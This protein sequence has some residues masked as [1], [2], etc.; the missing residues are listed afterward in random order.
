MISS[1]ALKVTPQLSTKVANKRAGTLR[2]LV[3][4]TPVNAAGHM[5]ALT[6][7]NPT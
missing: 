6:V 3:T 7:K 1:P 4:V 5:L 2:V